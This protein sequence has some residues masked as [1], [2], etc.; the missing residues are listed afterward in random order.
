MHLRAS[1]RETWP[2]GETRL[3]FHALLHDP[4]VDQ[5]VEHGADV[6]GLAVFIIDVIG[7][8]PDIDAEISRPSDGD[9]VVA[10]LIA[11]QRKP[12]VVTRQPHPAGAEHGVRDIDGAFDEAVITAKGLVD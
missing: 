6:F 3:G 5:L 2:G 7:M 4:P 9:R 11:D 10:I 12:A 1:R 8:F